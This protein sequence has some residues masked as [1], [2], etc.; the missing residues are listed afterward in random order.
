MEID[1]AIERGDIGCV[2]N[3]LTH[4]MV[5]MRGSGS[6]PKYADAILEV[7]I[8]LESWPQEVELNS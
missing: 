5:M 2:L 4:W 8:L 1:H 6:M 3:V 7:R